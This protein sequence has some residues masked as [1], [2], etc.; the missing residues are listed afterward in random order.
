MNKYDNQERHD[1]TS[2]IFTSTLL[3]LL[4]LG[5]LFS[6]TIY[7]SKL[8]SLF[9]LL[10]QKDKGMGSVTLSKNGTV[11][12]SRSIGYNLISDS[13]NIPATSTTKYRIGSIT[14]MFTATMIFQLIEEGK[15]HLSTTVDAYFPA[16]PNAN[17]I[18]I[19]NLLNHR[20]G[21]HNITSDPEYMTW[22]TQPKTHEEMMAVISKYPVD[23]QPDEKASYSNSNYIVLGY[24]LEKITQQSYQ[25]NLSKR[26][27][28]KIGLSHTY[29]GGRINSNS[30]ESHSYRFAGTWEQEKETDMSIPGGAGCL[31]STPTDLTRFIE[32]LFSYALVSKQS[33]TQMKT[34]TDRFGMG[35]RPIPFFAKK[36]YGHNGGIDGFRSSLA[37][38]PDDSV[39]ISYCT[40]GEVYPATEIVIGALSIYFNIEYSIPTFTTITL[41]SADLDKYRGEYSSK[42]MPLKIKI[43]KD[44]TQLFAQATGQGAFPLSPTGQDKFAFDEGGVKVEFNVSK[45]EFTITQRGTS[46]LFTK[47][48]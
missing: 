32:A 39:A 46:F 21:L 5:T 36:A 1:M 6:Q 16:L 45:S 29:V 26:I 7:K 12:Y 13:E 11:L 10:S 17:K 47:D 22:M 34:I 19:G 9:D 18:T 41:T 14:K 30:K 35:M 33:L 40:N 4:S 48:K 23:F 15:L 27:T 44:S 8:D 3:T 2:K 43:T 25:Q 24:I 42:Q 37:Y 20:S 31:V 28:S 38:F